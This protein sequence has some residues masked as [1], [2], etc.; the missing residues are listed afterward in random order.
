MEEVSLQLTV[1]RR[2]AFPR[3][4]HPVWGSGPLKM[5]LSPGP[6]WLLGHPHHSTDQCETVPSTT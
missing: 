4:A 6:W 5:A 3:S 2:F 1:K